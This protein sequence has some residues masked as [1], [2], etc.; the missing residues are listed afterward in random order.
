MKRSIKLSAA[1]FLLAVTLTSTSFSDRSTQAKAKITLDCPNSF[2]DWTQWRKKAVETALESRF[3][4]GI[5]SIHSKITTCRE[6]LMALGSKAQCFANLDRFSRQIS[7]NSSSEYSLGFHMSDVEYS[8]TTEREGIG[9][10]PASFLDSG[11]LKDMVESSA[12]RWPELASKIQSLGPKGTLAFP[13]STKYLKSGEGRL[14]VYIPG[15]SRDVFSQFTINAEQK[16]QLPGARSVITVV[17]K[18][19]QGNDLLNPQVYFSEF[20]EH[21]GN[22]YSCHK[23]P[24]ISI[25]PDESKFDFAAFGESLKTVNSIM[26]SYSNA[27]IVGIE[28]DDY[29]PEFGLNALSEETCSNAIHKT[30]KTAFNCADCHNG[31]DRGVMN[32]PSGLDLPLSNHTN[33]AENFYEGKAR[34]SAAHGDLNGDA[35]ECLV[36]EYYGDFK[37]VLKGRFNEWL[38][39]PECK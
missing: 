5:D 2:E 32:F 13:Y 34:L 39:Q 26:G 33:F 10:L 16:G 24:L 14:L 23:S 21:K 6:S 3:T 15:E 27:E 36:Q 8:R 31:S 30:R 25:R 18:D 12:D 11:L 7:R 22:C 20:S 19:E 38:M 29:G 37:D 1:V 4:T 35:L 17:K 9:S 28:E